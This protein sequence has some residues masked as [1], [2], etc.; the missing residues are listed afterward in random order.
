MANTC[1]F[2]LRII[3][4]KRNALTKLLDGFF[5][6]DT[7]I[8]CWVND[9]NTFNYFYLDFFGEC[10][11]SVQDS[12]LDELN[13]Y[14]KENDLTYE[15]WA[16]ELGSSFIEHFSFKD[17]MC[18]FEIIENVYTYDSYVYTPELSRCY[19]DGEYITDVDDLRT[20]LSYANFDCSFDELNENEKKII[21]LRVFKAEKNFGDIER[22]FD[23]EIGPSD[24]KDFTVDFESKNLKEKLVVEEFKCHEKYNFKD[25]K[26]IEIKSWN[27]N[28]TNI[29]CLFQECYNLEKV[30][31]PNNWKN[32]INCNFLFDQCYNLK[33]VKSPKTWSQIKYF[34]YLF[35]GCKSLKFI[36]LPSDF[37]EYANF[38]MFEGCNDIK[39]V[40]DNVELF[41]SK[42]KFVKVINITEYALMEAMY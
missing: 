1:T 10:K 3:S 41:E 30:T 25:Y 39:V 35:C 21:D 11:W 18:T 2:S 6:G 4:K 27:E 34:E 16:E 20:F 9:I 32:V 14:A 13:D 7:I 31:L 15:V 26:E 8:S 19:D 38:N 5:S 42:F 33:E 24:V 29:S 37:G 17:K 40:T 36:E 12:F 22:A 28:V 23:F